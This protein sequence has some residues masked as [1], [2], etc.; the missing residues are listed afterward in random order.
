MKKIW[1]LLIVVIFSQHLLAEDELFSLRA[2]TTWREYPIQ[3]P[4]VKFHKEKWVWT[5]SLTF[6]S[7]Q[8]VKLTTLAM[9]WRGEK[10]DQLS[11]SL[12]QKKARDNAVI[13][14]QENFVCDGTWNPIT[15]QLTFTPNEKIVAVNNYYLMVSF[16]KKVE[17]RIKKGRFSIVNAQLCQPPSSCSQL[18]SR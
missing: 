11:A 7:K 4:E 1:I 14:I 2:T 13:P 17:S 9:Q 16:P 5:C 12:Y 6:R 18:A 10:L 15:Q 8:P 3:L